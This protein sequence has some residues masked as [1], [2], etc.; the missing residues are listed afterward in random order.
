M[1]VCIYL[2]IC[3]YVYSH[4]YEHEPTPISNEII[5]AR[6][7][8]LIRGLTRWGCGITNIL[9]SRCCTTETPKLARNQLEKSKKTRTVP[10]PLS[11]L[12]RTSFSYAL[13]VLSAGC[14]LTHI[15]KHE[16]T[17]SSNEIV[18]HAMRVC[19]DYFIHTHIYERHSL[20]HCA[21]TRRAPT[22][23]ISFGLRVKVTVR[24]KVG[25]RVWVRG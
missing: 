15:Y 3:M 17:L 4:T 14:E 20:K 13:R 25:V 18:S 22:R 2:F 12:V 16:P 11:D 19:I 21:S 24:V 10:R 23:P 6:T 5:L 9:S 7:A 8:R 1:Y